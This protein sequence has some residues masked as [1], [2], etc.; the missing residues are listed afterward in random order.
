MP[1]KNE[2]DV[3]LVVEDENPV[4]RTF[5]E[6]LEGGKLGIQVLSAADATSALQI[7]SQVP[8]DLVILDWNLGAGLNGLDLLEDMFLFQPEVV[9]ILVTGF[10]NQATPLHA[11]RIGVRDY[12]DKAQDLTREKF[13]AAVT[14]QLDR[15]RPAKNQ[16]KIFRFL[17]SF[18]Q[19]IGGIVSCIDSKNALG[20]S[21]TEAG[22][23]QE[24]AQ[25]AARILHARGA[26]LYLLQENS[27]SAALF[28]WPPPDDSSALASLSTSYASLAL[29][30]PGEFLKIG[31]PLAPDKLG[32]VKNHLEN[33]AASAWFVPLKHGEK[34]LGVL[35][36]L[37]SDLPEAQ[38][39]THLIPVGS[40][41]GNLVFNFQLAVHT[42]QVLREALGKAIDLQADLASG[43]ISVESARPFVEE[44][45]SMGLTPEQLV[46]LQAIQSLTKKAGV[47][48]IQACTT[49]VQ[50]VSLLVSKSMGENL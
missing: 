11:M 28:S 37:D 19:T 13:L 36:L 17:E 5:L 23:F 3:I 18:K 35:E 34:M 31:F 48:A 21:T 42:R 2:L 49:M 20:G 39:P 24:M 38:I 44:I 25:A 45:Q 33:L 29:T 1:E 27:D 9:A 6:W 16:R 30:N 4:R 7:A 47:D 22:L 41:I 40:L 14:K 46:L 12:L 10:A 43:K 15:L 8:V 26:V 32:L 50:Q